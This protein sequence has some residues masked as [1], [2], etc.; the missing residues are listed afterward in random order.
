MKMAVCALNLAFI[1]TAV[2][3]LHK[4]E[5]EDPVPRDSFG[6]S[7]LEPPC[8]KIQCGEFSC[9]APLELKMDATC[10]GYCWAPD[11]V[12]ALDRHKAVPYNSTGFAVAMCDSAPATCT[13]PASTARCFKPSCKPGQVAHCAPGSCCASCTEA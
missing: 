7:Q 8:S 4:G 9:P 6:A 13:G 12:T 3:L 2:A 11:H 5:K 1:A 10:C